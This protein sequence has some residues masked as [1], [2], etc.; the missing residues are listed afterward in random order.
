MKKYLFYAME[1]KKMCFQHVLMNALD[2]KAAG[3]E[4]KIVFEGEAVKLP[5]VL[6]EEGNALY[7]RALDG[8]LI[9]GVCYACAH[10]LGVKEEIEALSLPFGRASNSA[11]VMPKLTPARPQAPSASSYRLPVLSSAGMSKNVSASVAES[12]TTL[13]RRFIVEPSA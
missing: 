8:G 9:A 13:F 1:G 2:L 5:P 4:V 12:D 11:C 6:A 7:K 3:H 10:M